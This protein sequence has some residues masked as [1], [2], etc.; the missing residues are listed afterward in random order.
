MKIQITPKITEILT[1]DLSYAE[2][3]SSLLKDEM[4]PFEKK[5]KMTSEEF[6]DKFEKGELGDDRVW[7]D[8]YSLALS[9]K[10]WDDTKK[11]IKKVIRAA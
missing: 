3:A 2:F 4:K 10:D 11:E 1:K 5:Y 6:F 7:F 9:T 8:W